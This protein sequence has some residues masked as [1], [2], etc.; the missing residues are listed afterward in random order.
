[1]RKARKLNRPQDGAALVVGLLLLL[2]MT[3]LA[4]SASNVSVL[5]ERMTRNVLEINTAFQFAE[6]MLRR[7]EREVRLWVEGALGGTLFHWRWNDANMPEL[8]VNPSDCSLSAPLGWSWDGA[9]TNPPWTNLS[10]VTSLDHP[11]PGYRHQR[12]LIELNDYVAGG[13][14]FSNPCRPVMEAGMQTVGQ[15]FLIVSRV[16]SPTGDAEAIVQSIFF[17]PG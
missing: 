15:Y 10:P 3:V 12:L 17:W 16:E 8:A 1:M 11:P 9:L 6:L 7:N 13:L 5:Q 2:I 4:L 14:I